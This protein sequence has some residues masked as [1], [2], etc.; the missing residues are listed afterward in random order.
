[1][2]ILSLV[3][4]DRLYID[5]H[6]HAK[7]VC[8]PYEEPLWS[9]REA[10]EWHKENGYHALFWTNHWEGDLFTPSRLAELNASGILALQGREIATNNYHLVVLYNPLRVPYEPSHPANP[11]NMYACVDA[12]FTRAL[13]DA[14]HRIG[15]LVVWA[16]P[17]LHDN[18][19]EF[20]P[21][22]EEWKQMG[23]DYVECISSGLPFSRKDE[24][25]EAGLGCVAGTDGHS[26]LKTVPGG[27]TV[28]DVDV[29][30]SEAIWK[31]LAS[32]LVDV[33]WD[34]TRA[35][36]NYWAIVFFGIL[37]LGVLVFVVC[38][39]VFFVVCH[40]VSKEASKPP[41]F[42]P[43][44]VPLPKGPVIDISRR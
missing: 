14:C 28:L 39:L 18:P 9:P 41:R 31:A 33:V 12:A 17:H 36:I 37:A 42:S 6:C 16:H 38:L 35:S 40:F 43:P 23:L 7:D 2:T 44:P 34:P 27:Y 32:G 15:A 19:C 21:T 24:V 20:N 29:A 22:L 11:P 13:I 1:M 30:S 8:L 26:S 10:L 25:R 3:S 5:T 4:C